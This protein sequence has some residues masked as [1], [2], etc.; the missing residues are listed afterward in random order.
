MF[1]LTLE[2]FPISPV[3]IAKSENF[4]KKQSLRDLTTN[5]H[6]KNQPTTI[7]KCL[8]NAECPL[9]ILTRFFIN[10]LPT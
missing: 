4:N 3:A 10:S 6:T 7:I 2:Y 5:N 9:I 1:Y 8:A